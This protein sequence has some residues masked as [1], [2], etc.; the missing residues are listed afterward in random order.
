MG[1]SFYL[2]MNPAR[3][4]RCRCWGLVAVLALSLAGG[5]SAQSPLSTIRGV[6]TDTSNAV[7]PGVGVVVTEAGARVPARSVVSDDRGEFDIRDLKPGTYRLTA[8]LAG[9]KSFVVDGIVLDSGQVRRID[10]TL[11]VGAATEHVTVEG[12][13]AVITTDSGAV[14]GSVTSLQYKDA[15]IVDAIPYP[16]WQGLLSTLP[17]V[18][19]Q[20]WNVSIAGQSGNGIT[21]QDDGVQNDRSGTQSVNMNTYDE[22]RVV[23]VNNT[24]DQARAASLNSTTKR[25][26]NS[27]RGMASYKHTNS[28]LGTRN[29]FAPEKDPYKFHDAYVEVG[30]PIIRDRTFFYVGW[31]HLEV[32][33]SS[34]QLASVPSSRMR[35]G[36]FSQL[37]RQLVDPLTGNPFPNNLIP[38]NR[39]NPTSQRVQ[40]LYIPEPNFGGADQLTNNH[41]YQFPYPDDY[42][43]AD[44]PTFRV[45]QNMT[46]KNSM[47]FRYMYYYSPYV[48]P[49]ALPGFARTRTRY[50][51]KGVF[52]DTHVFSPTVLNTLRFGFS[53]NVVKDGITV[54][55]FTPPRGNEAVAAIGLQGVNPRGLGGAGFPR[56]DISGLTSL[57]TV[58]GGVPDDAYDWSVDDAVTWAAGR[59]VWK[60]GFQYYDFNSFRS[61]VEEGTY[62]S[63]QFDGTYTGIGYADFLL[64]IPFRSIRRNP[65]QDRWLRAGELGLFVMDTFR[66][67][68]N[69]TL[70]YGLRWDYFSSPSYDDG[71][72]FNWDPDTGNVIIPQEALS[73]VS[74]LYP[75]TITIQAG[76]V[77]PE[78]KRTNF[79]PRLNVAYS[80]R[81]DLVL[82]GGY[83]LYTE[84]LSP[85]ARANGG[86]PFDIQETYFN[87]IDNGQPL[88]TFPNPFPGSLAEALVP[89]QSVSGYPT[90]VNNGVIHQFNLSTEKQIANVGLRLSYVGSRSRSLNYTLN[91]N[92]PEPSPIRFTADRRPYPQ[93]VGTSFVRDDG[94][95]N[96]DSLQ[97]EA[98]RRTGVV[99][100]NANYTWSS[101]LQNF[102]NTENPYDVTSHWGQE[103]A[104]PRHRAVV[105]TITELPWGRGQR[106]LSDAPA[107]VDQILGGWKLQTISYLASGKYFSPSF[108]GADPSGTN[109]SGGLPDRICDGNFPPDQRTIE[110]WFDPTCFAVPQ[111]GR[112]GNSGVNV[113]QGPGLH[114]HHLA[115]VKRFRIDEGLTLTYNAA[116]S[117]LFNKPHF[118]FPRNNISTANPGQITSTPGWSAENESERRV[119]MLLR[120]EW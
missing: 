56:M 114:V 108:S 53:G 77:I 70:D 106:F 65:L 6:V 118:S 13:S 85:F 46:G 18:V 64:G 100:F 39:I 88:F 102:L 75:K 21:M 17:G 97:V 2:P 45:D 42:F 20:G 86:G 31:T 29:F 55:G 36:D 103:G 68:R 48:L 87:R 116:V 105:T 40:N 11:V 22:V 47:F 33:A 112:F 84:R 98:V 50:H 96:Y 44:Y 51:D 66:P 1:T 7:V 73:S 27:F 61:V 8:E 101:S 82:R 92:K 76:E 23:T 81:D 57:Q 28:A 117:N 119:S 71:L 83:G 72:Q 54:D 10:V 74:P 99:T 120:L 32:P 67:T 60:F 14:S 15:P 59:H 94:R 43:R 115:L 37:N 93:F 3:S 104:N 89:S 30:G 52:S 110:R 90:Q 41:G 24:A 12:G 62:G 79:R 111:A 109:T 26:S 91:I 16:G 78:A 19:G 107:V 5:V 80:L 95:S 113:L 49:N 58:P 25:G 69:L 34:F 4:L 35:G 63:F 9:F 38:P